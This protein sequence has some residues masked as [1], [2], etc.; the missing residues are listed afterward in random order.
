MEAGAKQSNNLMQAFSLILRAILSKTGRL[1]ILK[2]SSIVA[3]LM[4]A[5]GVIRTGYA[6]PV[7]R[8]SP[9]TGPERPAETSLSPTPSVTVSPTPSVTV[10][11]TPSVTVSP[12][13]SV[14][15]SP[16]SS[17]SMSTGAEKQSQ[18]AGN[19]EKSPGDNVKSGG[20]NGKSAGDSTIRGALIAL[21][22]VCLGLIFTFGTQVF[23]FYLNRVKQRESLRRALAS[24]I[25]AFCEV[26]VEKEYIRDV[27]DVL[28][29]V[30]TPPTSKLPGARTFSIHGSF[31]RIYANNLQTFGILEP[32]LVEQIVGFYIEAETVIE[33]CSKLSN[34]SPTDSKRVAYCQAWREAALRLFRN[35]ISLRVRF[36]K[37]R[38]ATDDLLLT[39]L[40]T[41]VAALEP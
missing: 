3:L 18:L 26:I 33:L 23:F 1:T 25:S 12:A 39:K 4:L 36:P 34:V 7:D 6:A 27:M 21:G 22:G 41:A 17:V 19:N 24:E 5:D 13:P 20:D 30:K 9:S 8:A 10:S 40:Q 2:K 28:G 11:P 15:V 31:V 29:S 32:H 14:T 38:F 35:A 37:S 16:S